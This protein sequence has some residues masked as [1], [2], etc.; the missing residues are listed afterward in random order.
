MDAAKNREMK[1]KTEEY[2]ITKDMFES[3]FHHTLEQLDSSQISSKGHNK[4]GPVSPVAMPTRET[5]LLKQS[6]TSSSHM[7][8]TLSY[9]NQPQG[10]STSI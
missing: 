9:L 8:N 1:W 2:K 7:P 4:K 5:G 10:K 6:T 3:E